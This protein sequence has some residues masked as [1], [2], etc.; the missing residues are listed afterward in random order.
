MDVLEKAKKGYLFFDGGCGT[1]LQAAGLKAGELPER[2]NLE[3][4]EVIEKLHYDYLCAGADILKTNTFGANSL[5]FP[6]E[7]EH[8]C[9]FEGAF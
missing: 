7:G 6:D 5:K 1:I 9:F 4:S 3:H 8:R 2:W